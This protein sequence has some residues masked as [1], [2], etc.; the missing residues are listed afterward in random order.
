MELDHL[1]KR[2]GGDD[3]LS[4]LVLLAFKAYDASPDAVSKAIRK[5]LGVMAGRSASEEGKDRERTFLSHGGSVELHAWT[6]LEP[7]RLNDPFNNLTGEL[8]LFESKDLGH[9]SEAA[10]HSLPG[11][12][13]FRVR[14]RGKMRVTDREGGA[15]DFDIVKV[16]RLGERSK[17]YARPSCCTVLDAIPFPVENSLEARAEASSD[18][19][20]K[21]SVDIFL[22]WEGESEEREIEGMVNGRKARI[23]WFVL[24]D[25][26]GCPKDLENFTIALG[27]NTMWTAELFGLT[28][29][30]CFVASNCMGICRA[31]ETDD[32]EAVTSARK[33][34]ERTGEIGDID[35][36]LKTVYGTDDP[37]MRW[38]PPYYFFL[39]F[40]YVQDLFTMAA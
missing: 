31:I 40:N 34:Y 28:G 26:F 4:T 18:P 20:V 27:L 6:F 35:V 3:S 8:V 23:Q 39:L 33:L 17:Y 11:R 38:Q 32:A 21:T 29:S 13:K 10:F 5:V 37:V 7:K 16:E 24:R 15:S 30:S 14:M 1:L 19:T 2:T 25:L 36:L 12:V 9:T 22:N